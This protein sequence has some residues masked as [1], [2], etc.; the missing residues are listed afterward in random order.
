MER[1]LNETTVLGDDF[2]RYCSHTFLWMMTGLMITAITAF[3]VLASGLWIS[4]FSFSLAP[5]ILLVLQ[6][7]VVFTLTG[8]M[9]HLQPSTVRW[10]FIG[11]SVLTGINLS[12]LPL[13]YGVSTMFMAFGYTAL[14]FGC[15]AMIGATTKRDLSKF[16]TLLFAGLVTIIIMNVVNMFLHLDGMA[17]IMNYV[18]V[19]IFLGLTAYDMQ[20]IRAIYYSCQYD[21]DMIRKSTIYCALELYLDFINIFLAVLRIFGSSRDN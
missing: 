16:S 6:L 8:R 19:L 12:V 18:T 15:M 20:K 3:L 14:M 4:I 21:E 10:L 2:P 17:M 7:G 13:A 1:R 5:I 11:Y 9:M